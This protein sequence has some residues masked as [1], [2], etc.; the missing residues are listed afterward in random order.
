M[1][2]PSTISTVQRACQRAGRAM[3]RQEHR[4]F[5]QERGAIM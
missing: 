1:N 2:R 3:S 4:S 5:R